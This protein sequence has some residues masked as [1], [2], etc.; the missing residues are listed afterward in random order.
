MDAQPRP[1]NLLIGLALGTAGA[2]AGGIVGYFAVG[3]LAG[4]GF[5]ALAL[6]GVLVGIGAGWF[7]RERSLALAL[8]CG[9]LSLAIGV[10]AEWKHFPCVTDGSFGYF[11]AHLLDRQPVTLLMLAVGTFAG[12]WFAWRVGVRP[13]AR[14]DGAPTP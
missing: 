4:Q 6:P 7:P 3:W 1:A 14:A 5:Y 12:F 9:I 10:F 11:V 2:L 13:A 8:G